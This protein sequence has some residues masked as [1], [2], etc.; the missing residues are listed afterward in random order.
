VQVEYTLWAVNKKHTRRR[1][2]AGRYINRMSQNLDAKC[3]HFSNW[4]TIS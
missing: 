2:V 3:I 4:E 1:E